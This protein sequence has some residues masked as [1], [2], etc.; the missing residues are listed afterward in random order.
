MT[1]SERG[2]I[3]QTEKHVPCSDLS[4]AC[5]AY[6]GMFLCMRECVILMHEATRLSKTTNRMYAK[7]VAKFLQLDTIKRR[8]AHRAVLAAKST[9]C[10]QTRSVGRTPALHF[11]IFAVASGK[12]RDV[13]TLVMCLGLAGAN[14]TGYV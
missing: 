2:A 8:F 6:A 5:H 9:K 1:Q 4:E 10:L 13:V 11:Q 14:T 3:R 12:L 7:S